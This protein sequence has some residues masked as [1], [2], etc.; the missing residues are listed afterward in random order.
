[1][2][3]ALSQCLDELQAVWVE[4]DERRIERVSC[5]DFERIVL[6]GNDRIGVAALLE[7][8]VQLFFFVV[9]V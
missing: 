1:M 6:C 8:V 9:V 5:Y 7:I 3:V 2:G 4:A